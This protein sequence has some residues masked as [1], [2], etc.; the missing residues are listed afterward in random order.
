[1][2]GEPTLTKDERTELFLLQ[3]RGNMATAFQHSGVTPTNDDWCILRGVDEPT[4]R[5]IGEIGY[6]TGFNMHL[7]LVDIPKPPRPEVTP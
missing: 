3:V 6:R 1:M 5:Q 7:Q 2:M 4:M